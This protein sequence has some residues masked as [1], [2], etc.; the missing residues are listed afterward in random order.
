[1]LLFKHVI[2]GQLL[3]LAMERVV[4]YQPKQATMQQRRPVC[5][6]HPLLT[7]HE[8]LG[9]CVADRSQSIAWEHKGRAH[10]LHS[11]GFH[12]GVQA[13]SNSAHL[14]DCE[15]YSM[16]QDSLTGHALCPGIGLLMPRALPLDISYALC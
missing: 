3:V 10:V 6:S 2:A 12:D 13:M 5:R 11:S 1:M 16:W 15:R 7:M 4:L 9:M 8:A 14:Q